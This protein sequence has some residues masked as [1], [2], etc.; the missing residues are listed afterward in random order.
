MLKTTLATDAIIGSMTSPRT[1]GSS[2]VLLHHI[3]GSIEGHEGSWAY[4]K[5]GMGSISNALAKLAKEKGVDIFTDSSVE[6]IL[7][8]KNKFGEF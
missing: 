1:Q 3:M 6:R 8:E 4:V 7:V 5:G 2:Y